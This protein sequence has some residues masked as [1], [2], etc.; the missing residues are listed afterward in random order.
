M[1]SRRNIPPAYDEHIRQAS[2]TTRR[3]S[4]PPVHHESLPPLMLLQN[5]L[6]SQEAEIEHLTMDNRKLAS[7]HL[8]LRQ[9][10]VAA[11]EEAEKVREQIRST[12]NEGDIEIRI[13][14]DKIAKME[15]DIRASYSS[16]KELEEAHTEARSLVTARLELTTKI[17]QATTELDNSRSDVKKIP[18]M[19]MELDSLRQEHQRLR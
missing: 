11:K 4:L 10:L 19:R 6:A 1:D 14:L 8:L 18:E 5:K 9:D 16:K 13:L 3:A 7:S 17:Q 2:R 12:R 15:A